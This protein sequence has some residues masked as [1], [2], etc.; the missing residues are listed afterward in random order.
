MKV[1]ELWLREWVNPSLTAPELSAQLTMAGLEVDSLTPVAGEFSHVVVAKVLKTAPHPEADKLTLCDVD[2]GNGTPLSIV[3]GASNVRSGLIV[4]LALPGAKLPGGISIKETMLRGQ[5]SQGMLC[6]VTELGL[7]D[8]SDGILELAD[9][10]PVGADLREYLL[11]NDK[12]FDIDLTPNRADCFSI[13]G[14]AR[15]VAAL[16]GIPLRDVPSVVTPATTDAALNIHLEAPEACPQY[17]G[18]VIRNIH[19]HATTPF[20][21]KERLRRSGLRSVHPVVDVTNYVMLELGQPMHAFDLKSIEG[22]ITVRFGKPSETLLLLDGQTVTL[23]D[24]VLVIADS[25]KPL[26]LAGVMGGKASSVDTETT[27][28]FIE[29]A[30]FNP[31]MV[32]GVAR[33]FNLFSDSSQRFERGV[34][35]TLQSLALERATELLL[36]IVGGEPGPLTMVREANCMPSR[37]TIAFFPAKVKQL[38]G[39]SVTEDAMKSILT[40]LGMAIVDTGAHWDVSVPAHRFDI[41][42]DVDLVEE[43]VR[44]Y[45]YDNIK[46]APWM[47]VVQAGKANVSEGLIS[48]ISDFLCGRG[49]HEAINYSF[50]DPLLQQALY[51]ERPTMQLLNPIS[52]ELSEM[53]LGMWPGL[54]ASMI[55]NAHRQQSAIQLFEAGV[56]FDGNG[57]ALQER[58]CIAGLLTGQSG[59]LNWSEPSRAFD[60]YDVKG[61]LQ[62]LFSQLNL[63]DVQFVAATHDA[64]HPGQTAKIQI[65]GKDAGWIGALH[66]RLVDALEVSADV[67]LFELNLSSLVNAHTVRYQSISKYPQIRRDLSLLVSE[68]VSAAQIEASVRA[69]V[70]PAWL[71]SFDVFDLYT[72]EKIPSHKKS[73]AIALTLQDDHRTLVD[74]EINAIIGAIINQLD[75]EFAIILRD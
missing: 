36:G 2:A 57:D 50:V 65:A 35:S 34:D 28:I 30:Y 29:S 54:L 21:M 20:W 11:L 17:C 43:I 42:L 69:V 60:F 67:I 58:G 73:L 47:A 62:A 10:A 66:P 56:V 7:E 46:A 6:S 23:N 53:R 51:P 3:C 68:E 5:L 39:V 74:T 31:L 4:A 38:T 64:L 8:Q 55:Y 26:A 9:D 52:S 16:N 61:D 1:S 41:S 19:P 22:D 71:K 72:G 70:S 18:R 37:V 59:L 25:V 75:N 45:G 32:A 27:D 13:L 63:H 15:E 40:G 49:Y 14:V 48:Q 24:K 33:A 12:V 44:L